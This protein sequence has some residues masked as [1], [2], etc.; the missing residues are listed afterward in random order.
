[1]THNYFVKL[2]FDGTSYHGWQ[3]QKNTAETV[4]ATVNHAFT[5]ILRETCF[6]N[7]CGRTDTGVHAR[8]F[9][10]D[11]QV[12]GNNLQND[13]ERTLFKINRLLPEDIVI[14]GI[15]D[16]LP[17]ASARFAAT[18]RTYEY[19]ISLRKDPFLNNKAWQI[20]DIPDLKKMQKAAERLLHHKD[21]AAFCRT[22]G[23][24]KTTVCTIHHAEWVRT[25]D[26]YVFRITADRFLRNMVR[27]LTGTMMDVGR[28]KLSLTDWDAVIRG[29][30]R[31]K[32]GKSA[33][34]CGL[35]L[36]RVEYPKDTF[37]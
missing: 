17:L 28:G 27:A 32:A 37:K 19:L 1:M 4:Q 18:R 5:T 23:G 24:Q 7:G 29:R 11:L 6:L 36:T 30:D 33:L 15:Y 31:K 21:F 20:H 22:G 8:E 13:R 3:I 12:K 25:Q 26:L 35:Y 14:L 10:A 16:A 2:A 9:F 34:A